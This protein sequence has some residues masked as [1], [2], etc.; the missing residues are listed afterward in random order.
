RENAPRR[1]GGQGTRGARLVEWGGVAEPWERDGEPAR[2]GRGGAVFGQGGP[3]GAS[4]RATGESGGW[5]RGADPGAR[6]F[7]Q[8]SGVG[9][10]DRG[11]A[12]G[13]GLPAVGPPAIRSLVAAVDL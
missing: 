8:V 9:F 12:G 3:L 6:A 13:R 7:P 2:E 4:T 5:H 1:R 10:G 11:G